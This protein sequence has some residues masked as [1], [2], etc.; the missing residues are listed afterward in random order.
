M[1]AEDPVAFVMCGVPGAGK[2][3]HVQA[4]KAKN[5]H[6]VVIDGDAIS[7]ELYGN[8]PHQ[9]NWG[10]I[11]D[12]IEKAVKSAADQGRDVVVDGTHCRK[13]YREETL[14]LL[15]EYGYS[16][17]ELIVLDV[18]LSK[19][20]RQNS[21]RER[22]VPEYIIEQMHKDLAVSLRTVCQEGWSK[23]TFLR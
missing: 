4:L 13:E 7:S 2:T 20:L 12:E 17:I 16:H 19:A 6:L 9:S 21:Q 14:S 5:K 3:H 1:I 11:W 23:V 15:R 8:V 22:Q 18:A 10:E